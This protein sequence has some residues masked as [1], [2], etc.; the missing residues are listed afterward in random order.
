MWFAVVS[1][2]LSYPPPALPYNYNIYNVVCGGFRTII[3][4][5]PSSIFI[6]IIYKMWFVVVSVPLSYQPPALPL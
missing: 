4:P 1:V 3:L 5:T 6:I 2:P